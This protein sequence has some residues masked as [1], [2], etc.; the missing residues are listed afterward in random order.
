MTMKRKSLTKYILLSLLIIAGNNL[1][2]AQAVGS[3]TNYQSYRSA[4]KLVDAGNLVYCAGNGSLFS[5]NKTDN[6]VQKI[7]SINGLSDVNVQS[8]AY[9]KETETVV[10]A[11]QNSN[12]DLITGKDIYNLDDIKR[13]Q[14]MGN[15]TINQIFF[16]KKLAYLCCGFGIVVINIE[17]KEVKDT[18]YIG[19]E[20]R[21]INVLDLTSDQTYLYAATDEGIYRARID[22]PNL[23]DYSNWQKQSAVPHA[24]G[25]FSQI[26]NFAGKITI[27]YTPA[28]GRN[29]IYQFDGS[30]WNR[31]FP[32]ISKVYDMSVAF[33][34]RIIIT[35]EGDVYIFDTAGNMLDKIY[36]YDFGETETKGI[37]PRGARMD[38][39]GTYWVADNAYGLVYQKANQLWQ[40]ASP[41][42]PTDNKIFKLF[43]S[44]QTLWVAPGGRDE[45]WGNLWNKARFLKYSH[46]SWTSF[47]ESTYP[48]MDTLHDVTCI[49][50]D[51][52]D[53]EHI[54]VGCW[55]GGVFEFKGN[56]LVNLHNYLNS[57]LQTVIPK[58][59]FIG[60]GGM[61]IDKDGTLWVNNGG[62]AKV[63]SSYKNGTWQAYSF[64]EVANGPNFGDIVITDDGDKWIALSNRNRDIYVVKSGQED[65][66]HKWLRN[67]AYFNNGTKEIL[68]E[69]PE[70]YCLAKDQEGA[71]WVGSSKGIAVYDKPSR[72]WND[73]QQDPL[74][75]YARQPN[76]DQGDGIYHPLLASE[77]VTAI[78]VDGANQKW[79]GTK[80]NGV[81]LIS[82]DGEEELEHFTVDN[83]PLL[84]N[85]ITSIA[86]HSKSGE[87]FLGTSQGLISY[88]GV[89]TEPEK[90]FSD[91]YVYP[92]PVRE[93]YHGPIV[94]T[95][96][97]ED[98][99]V[100]ITDIS[101]KLVFHGTSSGG[102][103]SWDG[104]N[105]NGKRCHTGV[106]L[107]FMNSK[108]GQETFITKLLFIH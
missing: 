86:I 102:Q 59:N 74:S 30:N 12:I 18:Y 91:V 89:A 72:I 101:G 80:N 40:K 68:L 9:S 28:S 107:I 83:S 87:V 77:T 98:S 43:A 81:F 41:E 52:N 5:F 84:S 108:D 97:M 82:E 36:R 32:E 73:P 95:G 53:P 105:L 90:S 54:F 56:Q 96:L 55:G 69:M 20:G 47:D 33:N 13:K 3:W 17:K 46:G 39:D 64:P 31:V 42:G 16:D 62:V 65:S 71:I 26:E 45:A 78:A 63:L 25:S 93:T 61:A 8:I 88:K 4:S 21:Q 15:K 35:N 27:C 51:P 75:Q 99:D 1:L 24:D 44:G 57:T 94:V 38:V 103:L 29:E 2:F 7:N 58:A 37:S 19:H 11:Y 34:D 66:K 23:Q 10:V 14:I 60:I 85:E 100:K 67:V 6:S 106:Y 50:D 22:A 92:N 104:K 49:V 76:M 70:V 79:C 48:Q